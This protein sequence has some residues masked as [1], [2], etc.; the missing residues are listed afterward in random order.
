MYTL[1]QTDDIDSV[2]EL[3]ALALPDDKWVGDDHTFWVAR[4][5][6]GRPVGFCSAIFW[7]HRSAVFLSRAAVTVSARGTG[8][9]RRMIRT[10][11]AWARKQGAHRVVTYTVLKNYESIVNLLKCGFR[12]Y[13]PET[14]W[15][16]D[17]VHYFELK[18]AAAH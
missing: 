10:R 18:L 14:A 4:E 6:A 12:F 3:H 8:L 15:A 13:Q 7:P 9:Q 11:I 1:R 5:D 16:G 17:N 2:R